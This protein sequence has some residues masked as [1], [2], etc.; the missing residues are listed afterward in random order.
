[1]TEIDKLRVVIT[2]KTLV[3]HNQFYA[4]AAYLRDCERNEFVHYY[5]SKEICL[6]DTISKLDLV[7]IFQ[8]V[9][10]YLEYKGYQFDCEEAIKIKTLINKKFISLIR[11]IKI[12]YF[13]ISSAIEMREL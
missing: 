8:L 7:Y 11:D 6:I 3:A 9:E 2:L 5:V 10:S 1:M 4:F 13:L 12:D